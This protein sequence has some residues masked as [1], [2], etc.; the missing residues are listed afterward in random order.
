MENRIEEIDFFGREGKHGRD[1]LSKYLLEELIEVKKKLTIP[2]M[3][4]ILKICRKG[5]EFSI[6]STY[7][8]PKQPL[9]FRVGVKV[10]ME[11]IVVRHYANNVNAM[12]YAGAMIL[13]IFVG[14]RFAKLIPETI[15][16]IGIG[17]EACMLF[18][19]AFLMF[20]TPEEN[21]QEEINEPVKNLQNTIK[22]LSLVVGRMRGTLDPTQENKIRDIVRSELFELIGKGMERTFSKI[23]TDT[24]K[25]STPSK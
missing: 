1:I 19:L 3:V 16:L 22:D 17:V 24:S 14:L 7:Y 18:L 25:S 2:S 21:G 23:E 10:W 4:R 8:K 5:K 6:G 11:S 15:S 9:G 20:Y 12:V 13:L